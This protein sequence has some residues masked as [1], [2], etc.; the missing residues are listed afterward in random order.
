MLYR[1]ENIEIDTLNFHLTIDGIAAAIEPQ[2]FDLIIYLITHRDR[3]VTRQEI[4]DNIWAD[5]IVSDD[6][7]SSHIKKAR[8]VLGDDG[9]LQ[10]VIKTIHG[11]GFQFIADTEELNPQP[12]IASPQIA[13]TNKTDKSIAVLAFKDF[14]PEQDQEYFSD[15]LS[16]E[17][18][19]LLVKIPELRVISRTSSFSYKEKNKTT[20]QIG[21]ELKVTHLLEG[22]VRKSGDHLRITAQLIQVSDSSHLWS[23]TYDH[24]MDDIFKTQDEIA[25]AVTNQLQIKLYGESLKT[26]LVDPTAYTLYLQA[27]YL[28]HKF[29]GEATIQAEEIIQQS[30]SIDAN[31]AA[32]WYLLSKIIFRSTFYLYQM[33]FIEGLEASRE[34]VIKSLAL[35]NRYALAYA[36]LSIIN[37]LDWDFIKSI[38]NI[39]K[40]MALGRGDSSIIGIA[41]HNAMDM[42]NLDEA[43]KLLNQAIKLNQFSGIHY[44]NLGIVY[45]WL[46]R[47]DDAE[48]ALKRYITIKPGA[49]IQHTT[50]SAILL[51]QGKNKEALEEAK[52]EPHKFWNLLSQNCATFALNRTKE[53]NKLLHQFITDYSTNHPSSLACIYAFRGETNNAF[54]W[55][56]TAYQQR[57]PELVTRLNYSFFKKIQH[58]PRWF[59]FISKIGLP[60]KH[61]LLQ[62]HMFQESRHK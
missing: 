8:K 11:R 58:D 50:M 48:N 23:E 31:Y 20:R 5:R 52:K 33:P 44:Y 37:I 28:H 46:N 26:I 4:F 61:W 17:L 54:I 59:N 2:V 34:A 24:I 39:E 42:G 18:I 40:A 29:T 21:N 38:E 13:A 9:K 12:D 55:L 45:L 15:G 51:W 62:K 35:D 32:S 36:Q 16:E 25:Q 49:A 7:L 30:I 3:L 53:A 6:S 41:A 1:I 56:E 47:L 60:E 14:S 27:N 10:R 43:I 22:S 19:N 57:D